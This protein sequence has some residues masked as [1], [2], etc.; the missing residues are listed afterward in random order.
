MATK[1]N[2]S[3]PPAWMLALEYRAFSERVAMSVALPLLRRMP[4]GD[5]HHVIVLPGF[6]AGDGSTRPLRHL[7]RDLG[8]HSHGW[9]LGNNLGPTPEI[10]E[11]LGAL[12]ERVHAQ[13]EAPVSIVGWSLG[14]IFARELARAAP[15]KIRQVITLGSPIQMVAEDGSSAQMIWKRLQR[16]H[17]PDFATSRSVRA[18]YLPHLEVPSTSIYSKTDGVVHWQTALTRRTERAENIR[19]YGSHCGLGFN[20]SAL[21]AVADRLAQA[22]GEWSHFRAP[23]WMRGAYPNSDDLDVDRLPGD[24]TSVA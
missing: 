12:L 16:L 14:G 23:L 19:V 8:Y 2:I 5:G 24:A 22:E 10:L 21:F 3:A 13:A 17:S 9:R 20:N 15:D 11:G 4:K 1:T 18:G 7:L 6:T